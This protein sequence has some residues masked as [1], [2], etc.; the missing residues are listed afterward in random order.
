LPGRADYA[1]EDFPKSFLF[2]PVVGALIGVA[3]AATGVV[4][5]WIGVDD[6]I[7]AVFILFL[8][9][10]ITGGLHLDGLADTVDGF[11]CGKGQEDM[12]RIMR[13]PSAGPFGMTAI[14]LVLIGKFAA[15]WHVLQFGNV[16]TIIPVFV[17]SRWGMAFASFEAVYPRVTG[18]GK[19]FIGKVAPVTLMFSVLFALALTFFI[20]R[21]SIVPFFSITVFVAYFI[22][23][24]SDSKIGGV[25]GDVLGAINEITETVL[26]MT[27]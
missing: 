4:F 10:L 12:L 18:S 19:A 7:T 25:T 9:V 6:R 26:L 2:F 16:A 8:L 17:F 14:F 13:E 20:S 3:L 1:E 15:L 22:R 11:F 27:L 23:H 24:L 5:V 21:K